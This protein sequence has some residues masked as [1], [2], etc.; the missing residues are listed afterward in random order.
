MLR[1]E[2]VVSWT[3]PFENIMSF[4]EHLHDRS[5][6]YSSTAAARTFVVLC[7]LITGHP[8]PQQEKFLIEKS[9]NG[10]HGA[11]PQ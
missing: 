8:L 3:F 10:V 7:R 1:C 9:L 4:L 2:V 5:M 11:N 6:A